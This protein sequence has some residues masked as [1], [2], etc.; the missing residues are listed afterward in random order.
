MNILVAQLNCLTH[1]L[2]EALIISWLA[3]IQLFDFIV[4]YVPGSCHTATN[5]LSRRLK[6]EEENKNKEDINNFINSKLNIIKVLTSKVEDRTENIL[7][8]EYSKEYQRI[9]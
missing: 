1:D 6:V 9:T 2:S 7:K 4:R 3:W 8:P 5:G